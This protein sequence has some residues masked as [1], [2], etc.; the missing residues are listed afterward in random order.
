LWWFSS[1]ILQIFLSF[2][3]FDPFKG[4][5]KSRFL[6][7][8]HETTQSSWMYYLCKRKKKWDC[9]WRKSKLMQHG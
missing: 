3:F 6:E 5:Q 4:N 7:L 9:K 8:E 1:Y 2:K